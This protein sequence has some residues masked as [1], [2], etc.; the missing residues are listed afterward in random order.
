MLEW[1]EKEKCMKAILLFSGSGPILLL[2]SYPTLDDERFAKKLK[3]KWI[4]KYIAF[5]VTIF[6]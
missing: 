6:I 2:S 4:N 3:E 5:D 1:S